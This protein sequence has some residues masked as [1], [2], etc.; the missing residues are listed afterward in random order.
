MTLRSKWEGKS[1]IKIVRVGIWIYT[2]SLAL[3]LQ[4]SFRSWLWG[5]LKNIL[6]SFA[7]GD[8][9]INDSYLSNNLYPLLLCKKHPSATASQALNVT[10]TDAYFG[11][12]GSEEISVYTHTH[13]KERIGYNSQGALIS[14]YQMWVWQAYD[15]NTTMSEESWFNIWD[16]C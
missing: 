16:P 7:V 14:A 4:L 2:L 12:L 8:F 1:V 3:P 11:S 10:M 9:L 5:I 13:T 6:A 15:L